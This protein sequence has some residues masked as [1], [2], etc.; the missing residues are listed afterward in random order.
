M[1]PQPDYYADLELPRTADIQDIKKQFRKL[2]LK[3]HPDRNPG[4]EQEVNSKFQVIQSAHE[5]LSDPQQKARYDATLGPTSR[6]PTASGVKGNPWQDVGQRF[7][8]P[9]RRNPPQSGAQRWNS[10]FA[11]GVTPTA[12]Q[13]TTSDSEAKKNAARAWESMRKSQNNARPVPR[14][15]QPQPQAAAP[16]PPPPR[17]ET[18]RQR[19]QA[20][21]GNRK[22]SSQTRPSVTVDDHPAPFSPA[23]QARA[24]NT[25]KQ[26]SHAGP[27]PDPLSQFR[28][29]FSDSRQSTPYTTHGGEKTNPFDG[30]PIGRAKSTREPSQREGPSFANDSEFQSRKQRSSSVPKANQEVPADSRPVFP[31]EGQSRRNGTATTNFSDKPQPQGPGASAASGQ[32]STQAAAPSPNAN[33]ANEK[34]SLYASSTMSSFHEHQPH[35]SASSS[36][37]NFTTSMYTISQHFE[38]KQQS[39]SASSL[40]P[41]ATPSGGAQPLYPGL[42]TF[43][44]KQRQLLDRLITNLRPELHFKTNQGQCCGSSSMQVKDL[45]DQTSQYSF[46]FSVG[47]NTYDKTVPPHK[48]FPRGSADDINTKFANDSGSQTWQFQ[49]G[50]PELPGSPINRSS[51]GSRSSGRSSAPVQEQTQAPN[52][53]AATQSATAADGRFNP[54]GWSD[55]FGPQNFEPPPKVGSSASLS[56]TRGNRANSKKQRPAKTGAGFAVVED[57]SSDDEAYD[58]PGRK[59]QPTTGPADSPQAMDIDS[60]TPVSADASPRP[61][62]GARNMNVEPSRPEW[63]SGNINNLNGDAQV[64]DRGR[65]QF[66]AN[67]GGSEDSDEFRATL[68]DLRNVAPFTQDGQ[69]LKS[70]SDLKDNLPFDSKASGA[71]MNKIPQAKTLTFPDVPQAPRLPPTV[72][73]SSMKPNVPSWDKY[74]KDFELYLQQW[75]MMNARV[76]THF[77]TRMQ[78]ISEQRKSKG[79]SFLG[80]RNDNDI[81]EYYNSVQQ[82]NEVRARWN[83]A[84]EEHEKRLREF[85]AFRDKM[86]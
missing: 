55:K 27:I 14:E 44:E 22:S 86:K 68:S 4:R 67:A 43:E 74:L 25:G 34:P 45:A 18:A 48:P 63:R 9:P 7:P 3:Y 29:S 80:S 32:N 46:S 69:G 60:P 66:N 42:T 26:R 50:T 28:D 8:T 17:S 56:P 13:Q 77:S 78:H 70:L 31:P 24:S 65:K 73:I 58:W 83:Q 57:G 12:K 30:I 6:Y 21:F 1:V 54:E 38:K 59:A 10:R 82:D 40:I 35:P 84:C 72:A 11:P 20:S 15:P 5:V 47:G 61:L 81:Y 52:S 37:P 53:D 85:M 76:M 19:A 51:T 64:E 36:T 33:M 41:E 71:R 79:Y 75:D 49:A 16:P 23:D 39:P 2:A 62:S